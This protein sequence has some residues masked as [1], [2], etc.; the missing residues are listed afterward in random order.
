V[1]AEWTCNPAYYG[2]RDDCDCMCGVRDPDCDDASLR[3]LGCAA[4]ETC[5]SD[6]RCTAGRT[7][8]ATWTCNPSFYGV[9]D[10]CDCNCGAYDPDCSN[11]SLRLLGCAAGETCGT[12][13]RCTARTPPAS[14]TCNP[15]YYGVGDDCDCNCGAY[16]PDCANPSLRLLG[17]AAGESCGLDGR[18]ASAVTSDAGTGGAPSPTGAGCAA[19]SARRSMVAA[20][21]VLVALVP[22]AARRR[23]RAA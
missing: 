8:P 13:G 21:L 10:D 4:G 3:I 17:C 18:C 15:S 23:R 9:G 20:S 19:S 1:P 12:D 5:G 11:P 6:G 22:L 2:V 14:W 16:D 7:V